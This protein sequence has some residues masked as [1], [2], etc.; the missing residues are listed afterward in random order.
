MEVTEKIIHQLY[1]TTR[2]ISTGLNQ[3]LEPCGI[4]SSE[5]AIITTVKT[6]G[7]MSQNGLANYLNIEPPAISK[8]LANLERK[9][10]IE[11]REGCDKREKTVF[12]TNAALGQYA[13]WDDIVRQHRQRLLAGLSEERL[14]N[15]HESLKDIFAN[16]QQAK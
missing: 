3:Q 13:H 16:A 1:Q 7:A 9:G 10:L 8:S 5:W 4:Y 12:L 11:R 15:L 14:A 6:K 2:I